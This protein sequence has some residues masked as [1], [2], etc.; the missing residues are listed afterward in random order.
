MVA[1]NSPNHPENSGRTGF[2]IVEVL[3]ALVILAVGLLGMA[4]T[5]MLVVR[6]TTLADVTTERSVALQT[7]IERLQALPFDSL[8][9]GQDSLGMY[10][11]SWTVT[12]VGQWKNLE[13]VTVG[14]GLSSG[15]GFPTLASSVPD[16]FTFRVLRP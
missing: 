8:K 14:P 1:D 2:S 16:T 7:T 10:G 12:D 5:T 6:Q 15:S 11:I 4:G 9:A 13:F 3:I